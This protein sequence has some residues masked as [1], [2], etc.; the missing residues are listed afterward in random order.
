VDIQWRDGRLAQ[1][2]IR[3]MAGGAARL[4]YGSVTR[5]V[6]LAKGKTFHWNGR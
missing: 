5:D 4:R 1:A 2:T 6:K 3:S